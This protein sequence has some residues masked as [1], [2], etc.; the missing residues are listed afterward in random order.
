MKKWFLFLLLFQVQTVYATPEE[1][2]E[3]CTTMVNTFTEVTEE[4]S[5]I[6]DKCLNN[7]IEMC[8]KALK[9]LDPETCNQIIIILEDCLSTEYKAVMENPNTKK[10]AIYTLL[11]R[12]KLQE[13]INSKE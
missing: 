1:H 9:T 5:K 4:V 8:Q 6:M 7:D 13:W 10:L 11:V 2:A 12:D 3:Y